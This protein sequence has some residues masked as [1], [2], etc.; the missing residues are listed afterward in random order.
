[1]VDAAADGDD[2]GESFRDRARVAV[3]PDHHRAIGL[4][5]HAQQIGGGDV[6]H[7][8]QVG[9]DVG[10]AVEVVAPGHHRAVGGQR[11]A[12]LGPAATATTRPGRPVRST[13]R[14]SRCPR[15]PRC[16]RISRRGCAAPR[17]RSRSRRRARTGTS[18]CIGCCRP[19]PPR[20]RRTS[21]PGCEKPTGDRGDTHQSGRDIDLAEAVG[22]RTRAPC[23]RRVPTR[24]CRC[25]RRSRWRRSLPTE[26][27]SVHPG[28]VPRPPASALVAGAGASTSQSASTA[29]RQRS[30][31]PRRFGKRVGRHRNGDRAAW[32]TRI[33]RRSP[34][35]GPR[36]VVSRSIRL[37]LT[38]AG[39]VAALVHGWT[40][41]AR[42]P[43]QCARTGC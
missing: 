28:P 26:R 17:P 18:V 33:H 36:R 39:M 4:Q 41:D 14:R 1:M 13:A 31:C 38:G 11:Q 29:R 8:G 30:A 6:D 16:R 19:T 24:L 20:C 32:L 40:R 43:G 7:A 21:A 42:G 25:R 12:V 3:A 37:G 27:R 10:L 15:R 34:R 22:C 23:H 5:R 2:V 35:R 9:G